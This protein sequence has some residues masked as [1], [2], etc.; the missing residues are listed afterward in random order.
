MTHGI[1]PT[2]KHRVAIG[3]LTIL[4]L[5]FTHPMA[6]TAAEVGW[7]QDAEKA[8]ALLQKHSIEAAT[9]FCKACDAA[10][11]ASRAGANVKGA[12]LDQLNQDICEFCLQP[13]LTDVKQAQFSSFVVSVAGWQ[14]VLNGTV[15]GKNSVEYWHSV[16]HLGRYSE[17]AFHERIALDMKLQEANKEKMMQ[18]VQ[19]EHTRLDLKEHAR[20]KKLYPRLD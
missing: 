16:F 8:H 2:Y 5:R 14:S 19:D 6:A 9:Y 20:N 18:Q 15:F 1:A 12:V 11:K 17:K 10:E 7:K 3:I 13:S 4:L